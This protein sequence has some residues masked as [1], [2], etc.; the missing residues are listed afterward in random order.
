MSNNPDIRPWE[1]GIRLGDDNT[2]VSMTDTSLNLGDASR[3]GVDHGAGDGQLYY[4]GNDVSLVAYDT[5]ANKAVFSISRIF[6][7]K[8][9][10]AI[11]VREIGLFAN[12]S[13]NSSQ[14]STSHLSGSPS[15]IARTALAPADQFTIQPGEYKKVEYIIEVI[16]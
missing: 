7:N 16:A 4:Y 3:S 8:G 5:V 1:Y 15:L 9:A 2:F 11:D 10:V 6:E 12:T 14:T 13:A